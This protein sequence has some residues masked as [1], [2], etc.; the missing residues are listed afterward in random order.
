MDVVTGHADNTP[1]PS[2][3]VIRN[4]HPPNTLTTT[5]TTTTTPSSPTTPPSPPLQH[6]LSARTGVNNPAYVSDD[7][8]DYDN[9]EV[10]RSTGLTPSYSTTVQPSRQLPRGL[11][12]TNPLQNGVVLNANGLLAEDQMGVGKAD[13]ASWGTKQSWLEYAGSKRQPTSTDNLNDDTLTA[14]EMVMVERPILTELDFDQGFEQ[15]YAA[16]S[17]LTWVKRKARK[18]ACSCACVRGFLMHVLPFLRLLRG[19]SVK[20]DLPSDIIAGLTVGIMHI[21]QGMAYGQLASLSPVHGLYASFFPVIVYFFLGTS[22]HIS[23]GTFAVVSLMVGAALDKGMEEK[24]IVLTTWNET[25]QV[26]GTATSYL[27]DNSE[28]VLQ[29]KV[30]Y[31]MAITFAA[32]CMQLLLGIFRLGFLTVYLS[33]PLISGFTTGAACHVFTSQVKNILG[34]KMGRYAGPLKLIKSYRDLFTNLPNTNSVTLIASLVCIVVLVLV[35]EYINNNPKVKPKLKMPVPVEL[36][37]VVLGTVISSYVKLGENYGVGIVGN[38]PVGIPAPKVQQFTYLS[39][40]VSDAISIAVVGFACSVAMAKILAKKHDYEIDSNQELL[41][42]GTMNITCSFFSAYCSAASMSRSLVQESVGNK[43]QVCGLLSSGLLLVVLLVLGKYFET[44]P[45]C[46]LA[47]IIIVAL[48]GMFKQFGELKRLWSISLIDFMVWLVAF[49]STVLLD[50][51]LGLMAGI[52]F[53]LLTVIIRSQRPHA[54]LLGQ[55]PGTDL[56]KDVGVFKAAKELEHIKIFRFDSALYFANS[57]FFKA[58]VYKLIADPRV[59]KKMKRKAEKELLKVQVSKPSEEKPDKETVVQDDTHIPAEGSMPSGSTSQ[60]PSSTDTAS[61]TVDSRRPLGI[62]S[63]AEDFILPTVTDVYF[64]IIDCTSMSFVDSVGVKALQQVITEMRSYSIHVLL[65]HCKAAIREM[66]ER[67]GFYGTSGKE[68]QFMTVHDAVVYAQRVLVIVQGDRGR[69]RASTTSRRRSGQR[70]QQQ[71]LL[72]R[73]TGKQCVSGP[74]I[75][76]SLLDTCTRTGSG[77]L[78]PT[79]STPDFEDTKM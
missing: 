27:A 19:Y 20:K 31:A 71:Q 53:A 69:D 67:T 23:I 79:C 76:R 29:T 16:R 47:S 62:S 22:K 50:V 9:M 5:T 48:K 59:L 18:C 55:V 21:P 66:F 36:L 1:P 11:Q 32:G 74:A 72:Q 40:V 26:N 49:V 42:Y 57:D 25:V 2:G 8:T 33:D 41:A 78:L 58:S 63:K 46:I 68:C 51:D 60:S 61:D 54:C 64:I 7:D 77:T 30:A 38:V 14:D 52:I 70:Q 15:V 45:K 10:N 56:Y 13:V 43:T 12:R 44:L 28:E 39:D 4:R 65:A 75:D 34:L 3:H 6:P 17:P 37:V 35:K 24:G 73:S